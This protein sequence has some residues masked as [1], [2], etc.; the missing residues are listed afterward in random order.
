MTI[1]SMFPSLWLSAPNF[2]GAHPSGD[3]LI[4]GDASA[5]T[6]DSV[7]NAVT[8]SGTIRVVDD[9]GHSAYNFDKTNSITSAA[10][11]TGT[12]TFVYVFRR[13]S[14]TTDTGR[15]FTGSEG[16]RL[17]G[18]W[19]SFV[20]AYHVDAWVIEQKKS[21][22]QLECYIATN[23]AGKKNMWDVRLDKQLVTDSTLGAND[24]GQTVVGMPKQY[25]DQGGAAYVYEALVFE[26]VLSSAQ[27]EY[28]TAE[29][30][31]KYGL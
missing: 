3:Q 20:G 16:N 30:K 13:P 15:T 18:T 7:G 9:D 31:K 26:Y 23:N 12:Y 10:K 28:L 2:D 11:V 5:R 29:F 1:P 27:R 4:T 21:S 25:G 24:W 8:S 19:S 14:P 6:K 17:F 22:T